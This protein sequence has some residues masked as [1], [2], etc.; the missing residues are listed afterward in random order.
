MQ[1]TQTRL[2]FTPAVTTNSA[3]SKCYIDLAAALTAVNRKQHHQVQSDGTALAYHFTL[4]MKGADQTVKWCTATNNWTIAN[5]VKKA[6]VGWKKQLRHGGVKISDLPPYARRPRF[7]LDEGQISTTDEDL[8]LKKTLIPISCDGEAVFTEFD[9]PDGQKINFSSSNEITAV[10]L[11]DLTTG[12]DAGSFRMCLMGATAVAGAFRFGVV[13]EYLK[14]RRN[15]GSQPTIP[16]DEFPSLD[17]YMLQLYATAE[18]LSDDI[19]EAVD[20]YNIYRPYDEAGAAKLVPGGNV[21][22][23]ASARLPFSMSGVAPLGLLYLEFSG[24]NDEIYIDVE[25]ITE[26]S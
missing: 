20:G 24:V 14:S 13:S 22:S 25:A 10:P 17:G 18:E 4:S 5:A 7:A 11:T 2:T 3:N 8:A 12:D 16:A 23:Q 26:M 1:A 6:A 19:I 9:A 21:S 15:M